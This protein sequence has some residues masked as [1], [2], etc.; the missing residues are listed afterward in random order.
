MVAVFASGVIGR[1][2]W[3]ATGYHP[4]RTA[5]TTALDLVLNIGFGVWALI[6]VLNGAGA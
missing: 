3:L 1:I 4:P 5:R 2:I 6:L